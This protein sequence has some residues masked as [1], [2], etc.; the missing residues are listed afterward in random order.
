MDT[1]LRGASVYFT[2]MVIMQLSGRRT[3]AQMTPFDFI[4]LLIISETTQQALLGDDFSITNAVILIIVL[5]TLDVALSYVKRRIPQA[6]LL[7]DGSP[8]VLISN[9]V[10]DEKA[11]ARTRVT[12][13]DVLTAAREQGI[14]RLDQIRFAVLEA[15]SGIS[16]VPKQ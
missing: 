7:V 14:A 4:L 6:G 11:L 2:L 8:T 3:L 5:V 13:D 12:I 15:S 10:P 9:G 1:V 16:I